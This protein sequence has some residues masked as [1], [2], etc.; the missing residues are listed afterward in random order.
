MSGLQKTFPVVLGRRY[1]G[2]A[3][4]KWPVSVSPQPG[5]LLSSWL[6]RLAHANGIPPRYFGAAIGLHAV[7]W[8]AKLDRTLP[9]PI[10]DLLEKHTEVLRVDI[11][12]LSLVS[13][14]L[15][16]LRLPLR[17][18]PSMEL[19]EASQPFWLQF[20]P[21]CLAEDESPQYRREWTLAT[22]V[23]CFRHGCRLR[24]RCPNCGSG[25][26]PFR[27]KRL[28]GQ[29]I[30]SFCNSDLARPTAKSNPPVLRIERLVAD[31]LRLH[32]AGHRAPNGRSILD[33]LAQ[34][35]FPSNGLPPRPLQRLPLRERYRLFQRLAD[36]DLPRTYAGSRASSRYWALIA[37]A[38]KSHIALHDKLATVVAG[39]A[40][41]GVVE[42][43][44]TIDL[45]DI[46]KAADRVFDRKGL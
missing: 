5:E 12:A 32:S 46:L 25:L 21:T 41:Q 7:N 40:N 4:E 3:G 37:T 38:S 20:C 1:A 33:P 22:R 11:A 44:P 13:D 8:S 35:R 43:V 34:C 6:H 26:A 2:V 31:L 42:K 16:Q 27:Q 17:P 23:T 14:P 24:D 28:V 29:R 45:M 30:C 39:A 36:G 18:I 9:T 19:K 15:A 10:L